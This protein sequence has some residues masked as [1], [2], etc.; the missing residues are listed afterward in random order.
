MPEDGIILLLMAW[1]AGLAM[2]LGAILGRTLKLQNRWKNTELR[3]FVMAFGG[4]ALY[5]LTI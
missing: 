5:S 1:I 3:H 2:V 4:G